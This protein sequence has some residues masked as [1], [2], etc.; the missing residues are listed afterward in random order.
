MKLSDHFSK[1]AI[2]AAPGD[3][4]TLV[5]QKM[6]QHNV[7]AVII[8]E[9]RR[10]VGIV[11]D[12][13]LALALSAHGIS[14]RAEVSKIMTKH[15]V[16][17]PEDAGIFTA[18]RYMRECGVRRLPLV[19]GADR[20]VG[21]VT[22]DDL[23]ECI[24]TE[25]YNL[26]KGIEGEV[27]VR[28]RAYSASRAPC[29]RSGDTGVLPAESEQAPLSINIKE[30]EH[31]C[32]VSSSHFAPARWRWVWPS[33][34]RLSRPPPCRSTSPRSPRSSRSPISVTRTAPTVTAITGAGITATTAIS[35]SAVGANHPASWVQP[36]SHK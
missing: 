27:K 4:L 29:A 2:T 15:V 9:E 34:C 8:A 24:G 6:E 33:P 20:V 16:A 32:P 5:A 26:A 14:P 31:R 21:M 25:L 17:I 11:T 36:D 1:Q 28:R 10:A 22:L 35:T 18:T 7:G 19:D 13:D 30:G 3:S 12:R 23:L